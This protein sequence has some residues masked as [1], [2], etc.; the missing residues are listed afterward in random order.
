MNIHM[1]LIS[2]LTVTA[3][4]AMTAAGG[5]AWAESSSAVADGMKVTLEYALSLPDKTVLESNVG[6]EPISYIH[7]KHQIIPG[8]E[9]AMTGMK[10]GEKKHVTV[11][12]E[13]AYGPYDEKKKVSVPKNRIPAEATVGSRLR[14]QDGQEVKVVSIEGDSATLDMNHPLAGK[15]LVFD[16]HVLNVEKPSGT[17][18]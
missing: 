5:S 11:S 8:L 3:G 13:E 10:V 15:A 14:S 16:V 1:Q 9:K 6:R 4:I 17:S 2:V 12:A 18:K 7:G